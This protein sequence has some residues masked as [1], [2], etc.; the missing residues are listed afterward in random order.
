MYDQQVLLDSYDLPKY[1]LD[2][3]RMDGPFS[4][5]G[6]TMFDTKT[7]DMERDPVER[8]FTAGSYDLV[9]AVDVLHA[10]EFIGATLED[11]RKLLKAGGSLLMIVITQQTPAYNTTYSVL[12]GC[13]AGKQFDLLLPTCSWCSNLLHFIPSYISLALTKA[14]C[15]KLLVLLLIK[16]ILNM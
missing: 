7:L 6:R 8:G 9:I 12:K 14:S 11:T 2:F 5:D 10:T 15:L 16:G 3:L 4:N 1:P 13:W